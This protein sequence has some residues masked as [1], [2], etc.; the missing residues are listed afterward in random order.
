MQIYIERGGATHGP[1][2]LEQVQELLA[3]GALLAVDNA[4][5]EGLA[6][7]MPLGQVVDM[8]ANETVP[9]SAPP[10]TMTTATAQGKKMRM[11][12]LIIGLAGV[13]CVAGLAL[14][15]FWLLSRTGAT[16]AFTV[17]GP[18]A[19]VQEVQLNVNGRPVTWAVQESKPFL[20]PRESFLPPSEVKLELADRR[21]RP[22]SSRM[23]KT[24]YGGKADWGT[25][26][27]VYPNGQVEIT[28]DPSGAAVTTL[29][30]N[31]L[32]ITPLTLE[33]QPPGGQFLRLTKSG[34]I[35]ASVQLT[36]EDA[37]TASKKI[38]LR[39]GDKDSLRQGG[40]VVAWGAQPDFNYGQTR[41]PAT[42]N[43]VVAVAAGGIFSMVLKQDGTVVTFGSNFEE[44]SGGAIK[45]VPRFPVPAGL[46][47]VVAI[48]A[49]SS[50]A[51]A[52]KQDGTVVAWGFNTEG[53]CN[54]PAGL[55]D[56]VA[57]AAGY[58]RTAALKQDGTVVAWGNNK[59]GLCNVPPGLKEVVAIAMGVEHTT[60]LKKDGTL[61]SWGDA[62]YQ[63]DVDMPE[64]LKDVAAVSL[65]MRHTSVLKRDG[66]VIVWGVDDAGQC[67]VPAGLN[68]VVAIAA[69]AYHTLALKGDGTVVAWGGKPSKED[70]VRTFAGQATVPQGLSKV[71]A[72]SAGEGHSLAVWAE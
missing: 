66:T 57:I 29:S 23:V 21:F 8:A 53:E 48:A 63:G 71:V 62:D 58:N 33:K 69:G 1:Y 50:H 52:L 72:I 56:V 59:I 34:Y 70:G 24:R 22:M 39:Q 7:W 54:V 19:A 32:G 6:G 17:S 20:I 49:G 3:T 40:K 64:G 61:V 18:G 2:S 36:V 45:N 46:S 16:L 15:H 14:L 67:A 11:V 51:V 68:G 41:I 4:W 12:G 60:V 13:G 25:L 9:A 28:S 44:K 37:K 30:G 47:G 31:Q 26:E 35:P 55:K 42:L 38:S 43:G 5:H 10:A 27:L 65:G